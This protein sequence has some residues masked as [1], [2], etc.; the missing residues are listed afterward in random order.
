MHTYTH[1]HFQ[2]VAEGNSR[3]ILG[4]C[5]ACVNVLKSYT[6]LGRSPAHQIVSHFAYKLQQGRITGNE[7]Y[8][9][10]AGCHARHGGQGDQEVPP[11]KVIPVAR[12]RHGAK[13]DYND[14]AY[15]CQH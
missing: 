10:H 11:V 13:G 12:L 8:S 7:R 4:D 2:A 3:C 5:S 6:I 9:P 1:G 14:R 15:R